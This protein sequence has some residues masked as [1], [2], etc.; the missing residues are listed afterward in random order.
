MNIK[1]ISV[2]FLAIGTATLTSLGVLK[3]VQYVTT[4]KPPEPTEKKVSVVIYMEPEIE[5]TNEVCEETYGK[6]SKVMYVETEELHV[7]VTNGV[8]LRLYPKH[9]SP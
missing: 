3:I 4:P 2:I 1:D 8:E 7:C 9:I 6:G 5:R